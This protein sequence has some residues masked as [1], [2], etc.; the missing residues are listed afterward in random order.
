MPGAIKKYSMKKH[1]AKD[2]VKNSIE[3]GLINMINPLYH[4]R[5]FIGAE[6][7]N[8]ILK[9][10][11]L[12]DNTCKYIGEF[13]GLNLEEKDREIIKKNRLVFMCMTGGLWLFQ[14]IQTLFEPIFFPLD[15]KKLSLGSHLILMVASSSLYFIIKT[16]F[17]FKIKED[18]S[19][20]NIY[21][22]DDNSSPY[23]KKTYKLSDY[24]AT[25]PIKESLRLPF[26]LGVN[27]KGQVIVADL[28]Q[29]KNILIAGIP[30][31]GKSVILNS[32]ITS[33]NYLSGRYNQDCL[34][35]LV[36]FKSVELCFYNKFDNTVFVE[37]LED[38]EKK[39][40]KL[41]AEMERRYKAMK[42]KATN[43]CKLSNREDF[44]FIILVIDEVSEIKLNAKD[45]KEAERIERKVIRLQNKGRAA[46]IVTIIATQKP[47]HRQLNPDIKSNSNVTVSC[48]IANKVTQNIVGVAGTE[49]LEPGEF[50]TVLEGQTEG[51]IYK[52]FYVDMSEDCPRD[53]LNYN[54]ILKVK[55]GIDLEKH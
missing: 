23:L 1:S 38:F 51:Q 21:N 2:S 3:Q 36:D 20:K 29:L 44:P 9:K 22:S 16:R 52:S 37:T 35:I 53:H 18:D 30:G 39:L 34:F 55:G 5:E 7:L 47:N 28:A 11:K 13:I 25:T 42:G 41:L 4:I 19:D 17:V 24:L 48:K 46:C 45:D 27:T 6:G 26:L 8:K 33:L 31:G 15:L 54:Q 40:D 43:V 49:M 32:F 12:S 14:L 10:V 50:K